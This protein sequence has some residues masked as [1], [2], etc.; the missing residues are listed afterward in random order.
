MSLE[1]DAC[2]ESHDHERGDGPEK[3]IES[4]EQREEEAGVRTPRRSR[5]GVSAKTAGHHVQHIFDKTGVRTRSA[6]LGDLLVGLAGGEH[7]V[8]R[9]RAQSALVRLAQQ[10]GL[11]VGSGEDPHRTPEPARLR[12]AVVASAVEPLVMTTGHSPI[13]ASVDAW[14]ELLFAVGSNGE[15]ESGGCEM[16]PMR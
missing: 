10:L 2:D 15:P 11:R 3:E 4:A 1:H 14:G 16:S 12:L 8:D 5:L 7:R 6:G 9:L 13:D